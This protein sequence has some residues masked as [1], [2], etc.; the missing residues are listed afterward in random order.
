MKKKLLAAC[1]S[2]IFFT[3]FAG[4][5]N[6]PSADK[7][8]DIV[9]PQ[10]IPDDIGEKKLSDMSPSDKAEIQSLYG[11]YWPGGEKIQCAEIGDNTLVV[12][13]I[14]MSSSYENVRWGKVSDMWVCC[15]YGKDET[16]YE[17][18]DRRVVLKFIKDGSN[19]K[20]WQ[21][22]ARMGQK[23]GPFTKGKDVE[24]IEDGDKTYYVYDKNDS[25]S[26]KMT[27]PIAQ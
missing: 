13:S 6:N 5:N 23:W 4:C 9:V 18:K 22:V 11:C 3:V 1:I 26:H 7:T 24:K 17:P 25:A 2:L 19:L 21:Y 15:S 16:D 12:Y 20:V 27:K 8:D 10:F 14:A